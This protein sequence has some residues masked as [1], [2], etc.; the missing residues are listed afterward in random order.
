M[1][2]DARGPVCTGCWAKFTDER[3]ASATAAAPG[4]AAPAEPAVPA[5]RRQAGPAKGA[6]R[7]R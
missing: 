4:Q 6:G 7:A 1:P 3:W 5:H 2:A